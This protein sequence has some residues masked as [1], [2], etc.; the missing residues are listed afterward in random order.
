MTVSVKDF[1]L[2]DASVL[3]DTKEVLFPQF[4]APFVIRSLTADEMTNIRKEATRRTR[5]KKT[6]QLITELDDEKLIDLLMVSAVKQ[7]DLT[8]SEL[9]KHYGTS[10]NSGATLRKMLKAGQY[11]ELATEIQELNGYD[12]DELAEEV[13]N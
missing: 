6:G 11:D 2:A 9:Q 7:P 4:K 10:G 1:M 8:D 13:K 3:E 5:S 12:V